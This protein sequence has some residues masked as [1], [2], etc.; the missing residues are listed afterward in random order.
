MIKSRKHQLG[1]VLLLACICVPLLGAEPN[2][3]TIELEFEISSAR[4]SMSQIRSLRPP[5]GSTHFAKLY[6][7]GRWNSQPIKDEDP[8]LAILSTTAARAMSPTQRELVSTLPF[9]SIDFGKARGNHTYFRLFGVGEYDTQ[10]MVKAFIEALENKANKEVQHYLNKIKESKKKIAEV[11]KELP[12]KQKQLKEAELKFKEIKNTRYSPDNSNE[13][14]RKSMETVFQ[15][16]KTLDTLEIELAGI[17]DK[18]KKILKYRQ[19]KYADDAKKFSSETLDKLD[20][21]YVEQLIE[22]SSAKSRQEAAVQI[23]EREKEFLVLFN[24]RINLEE[25]VKQLKRDLGSAE[26]NLSIFENI[27]ANPL[28]EMRPPKVFRNKVTI[29]PVR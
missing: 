29:Y 24:R 5:F 21:M 16:D 2:E 17:Q 1:I 8:V 26:N 11:K 25:E 23:R 20:Q 13:T 19:N 27:L 15:M 3:A 12:E 18:L 6:I 22:L 10:K 9:K 28:P 4:P 7:R 14:Y